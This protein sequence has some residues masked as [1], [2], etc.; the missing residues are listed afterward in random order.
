VTQDVRRGRLYVALAAITWS[1]AGLFQRELTVGLATQ[2][3]GRALFAM[4][5]GASSP[6]S[7]RAAGPASQSPR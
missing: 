7:A 3:A 6:R 4:L 5:A 2:L 1:T